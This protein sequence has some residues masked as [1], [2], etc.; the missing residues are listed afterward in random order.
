MVIFKFYFKKTHLIVFRIIF[1]FSIV[2]KFKIQ[3]KNQRLKLFRPQ[4]LYN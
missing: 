1:K 3:I 2:G 4:N